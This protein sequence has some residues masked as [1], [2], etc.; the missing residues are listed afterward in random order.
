MAL[1]TKTFSWGSYAYKSESNAYVVEL[2]LT[3]NSVDQT[4][5]SSSISYKLVLKSGSNNRFTGQIDS[6]IKLNGAQVASGS[7][8]I[9]AA[10]NSSW[11]LLEGTVDV[12]HGQDGSLNM[13]IVVSINTYN[14]FA[15]PKKTMEWSWTLTNIPR[16]SSFGTITNAVLGQKMRVNIKRNSNSFSHIVY[17]YL[18]NNQWDKGTQGETYAD[19]DL[20]MELAEQSKESSTFDLQVLIRTFDGANQ[21]GSDVRKNVTVT[22]PENEQTRPVVTVAPEAVKAFKEQY[23]QNQTAIK[24][25]ELSAECK[26]GATV[27]EVYVTVEGKR[28]AKGD[29]TT[30]LAGTGTVKIVATAVDSRGFTGTEE[31][32]I[33]VVPHYRPQL[34]AQAYRCD[35]AGVAKDNGE[36]LKIVAVAEYAPV[37]GNYAYLYYQYKSEGAEE[38]SGRVNLAA[39]PEMQLSA[40]T[41]ALLQG[42]L[43]KEN[44]Y[45][46][47]IVARDAV[48]EE[49]TVTVAIHSERIF[50]H[51]R[52]GGKGLGLGG[53]C[54]QDDLLDVHWNG[55]I[56][57]GLVI[58]DGVGSVYITV[59]EEDPS[60][61]FAGVWEKVE[62]GVPPAVKMWVRTG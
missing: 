60:G 28:Y 58:G 15:P 52:P 57:K 27:K 47:Q 40:N 37:P 38:Y 6:V 36:Y 54:D 33:E 48:G 30:P 43:L 12:K 25:A 21:V 49:T 42:N 35:S 8:K 44:A 62:Q 3:E 17:Y 11:V 7:K 19:I 18:G 23:L 31:T 41:A 9:T 61:V 24:V 2:T 39:G 5:I 53:Y 20:P 4:N 45:F 50:R 10:Y 13:P 32:E 51:K 26:Y 14:D 1:Q 56:R 16:E 46:V 34:Q 55:R 59:T 22:V 29:T